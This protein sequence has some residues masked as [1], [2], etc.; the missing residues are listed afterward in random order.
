ME[1]NSKKEIIIAVFVGLTAGLV[2]SYV[3]SSLRQK[4]LVRENKKA[5]QKINNEKP[6]I[7]LNKNQE[8][9]SHLSLNSLTNQS[10]VATP[11]VELIGQAPKNSILVLFTENEEKIIDLKDQENFNLKVNLIEG[12]NKLNLTNLL[13]DNQQESLN[14]TIIYQKSS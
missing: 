9:V 4:P 8:V 5:A 2:F 1:D 12:E 6:T 3:L 11:E 10:I 13:K 14:L 7:N